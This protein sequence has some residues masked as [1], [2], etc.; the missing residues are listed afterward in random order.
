MAESVVAS[1]S[2]SLSAASPIGIFDSGVGGLSVLRHVRSCLKNE[3]LIYV[4]DAR[5][6]PYG[7]RTE[8]EIEQ[9]TLRTGAFLLSLD[10]KAIVVAC[11]TATAVA[12][13]ALRDAY[14]SLIVVGVEP[15]LKPAVLVSRSKIIGVLA[16]EAT[17]A[18]DKFR[19]LR[20]QLSKDGTVQFLPQ[21]CNGLADQIERGEF[22]TIETMKMLHRYIA[23]LL[24]QGA[25]TLVLGCTHYPFV[26]PQIEV[27]IRAT[28]NS[29]IT[30]IDTGAAVA[31]QVQGQLTQRGLIIDDESK[32]SL[33]AFTTGNTAALERAFLT[34]LGLQI[35]VA[36]GD[37]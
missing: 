31:R 28:T 12:I 7:E 19:I 3:Q 9:R 16:T 21:S 10:V 20:D 34:L 27:V 18:S 13:A 30:I 24:Q 6:A 26:L 25:D 29:P 5:Y 11:N 14:P 15:G 36:S 23:P 8:S 4:S 32:A 2:A 37:F 22:S 33:R 35:N 17:L 1:L